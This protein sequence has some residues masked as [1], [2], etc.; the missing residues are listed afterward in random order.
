MVD[1]CEVSA[2]APGQRRLP[3]TDENREQKQMELADK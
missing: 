2:D 1:Q 3:A